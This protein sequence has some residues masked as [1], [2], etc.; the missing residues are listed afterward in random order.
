MSNYNYFERSVLLQEIL[1][2]NKFFNKK[3]SQEDLEHVKELIIVQ[4]EI[5]FQNA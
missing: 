3:I 1:S 2:K 4:I 5:N